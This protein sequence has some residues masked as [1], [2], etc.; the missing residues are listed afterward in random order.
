MVSHS[1]VHKEYSH[2]KQDLP[3]TKSENTKHKLAHSWATTF[4][5]KI[6]Q[7]TFILRLFTRLY[8]LFKTRSSCR[9][10]FLVAPIGN[11]ADINL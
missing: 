6:N 10:I 11:R 3:V 4:V 5:K 7:F 9:R 2:P 8:L 1:S